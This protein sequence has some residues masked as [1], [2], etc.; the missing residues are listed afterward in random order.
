MPKYVSPTRDNP[1]IPAS[2]WGCILLFF[3]ITF[4]SAAL[5]SGYY[6]MLP[7]LAGIGISA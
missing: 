2:A 3:C 7:Y 4:I 1:S 6:F 5:E